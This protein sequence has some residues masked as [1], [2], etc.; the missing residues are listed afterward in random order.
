MYYR[1]FPTFGWLN[2][3]G[4]H[5]SNSTKYTT[6]IVQGTL[7]M[8]SGA[9]PYLGCSGPRYN[10]TTAG[11]GGPDTGRT[12]LSEVWYYMHAYGKPQHGVTLPVNATGS[13]TSCCTTPGCLSYLERTPAS[14]RHGIAS[15][16]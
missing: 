9:V 10:T 7:A 8:A 14:V 11:Y 1:R 16:Y 4:I 5:P 3:V 15:Q 12:Q 6:S 13:I 2:A